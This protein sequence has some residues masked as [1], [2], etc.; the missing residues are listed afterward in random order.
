MS[1]VYFPSRNTLEEAVIEALQFYDGEA[2][3]E[4]IMQR[5]LKFC[6]CRKKS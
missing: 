6:I 2:T 3:T 4:Q 1:K 5:L